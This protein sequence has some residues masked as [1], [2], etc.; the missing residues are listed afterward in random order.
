MSH[1]VYGIIEDEV[2]APMPVISFGV[3]DEM[4]GYVYSIIAL[5]EGEN[6]I[7]DAD[8]VSINAYGNEGCIVLTGAEGRE[9]RVYD[10]S[11]RQLHHSRSAHA[12]ESYGVPATGIYLIKVTGVETKRVVVV[13]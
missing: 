3:E 7:D 12:T 5:F 6:G 11:G 8:A 2:V 1:P 10:I 4:L 13:R 9:V